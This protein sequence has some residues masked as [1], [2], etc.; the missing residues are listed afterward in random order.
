MTFRFLRGNLGLMH[1]EITVEELTQNLAKVLQGVRQGDHITICEEGEPIASIEPARRIIAD[2]GKPRQRL[3]DYR[4][5]PLPE[6][7]DFD[8]LEYLMQDRAKGRR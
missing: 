8:P 1:R 2:G 5:T 6:P 4:P 3:G 7:V